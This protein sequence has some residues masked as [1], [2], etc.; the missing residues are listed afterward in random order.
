MIALTAA[1]EGGEGEGATIQKSLIVISFCNFRLSF[2][3]ILCFSVLCAHDFSI[4][5]YFHFS[6]AS[7]CHMPFCTILRSISINC[8]RI[9]RPTQNTKKKNESNAKKLYFHFPGV[10]I[11]IIAK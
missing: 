7:M 8:N 2:S 5:F 10:S 6:H 11:I 4:S 1:V 9:F 3:S